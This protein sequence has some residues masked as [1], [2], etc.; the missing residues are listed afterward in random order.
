MSPNISYKQSVMQNAYFFLLIF[1]TEKSLC[2]NQ[3][4]GATC[5]LHL[6]ISSTLIDVTRTKSPSL[7]MGHHEKQTKNQLID[8]KIELYSPFSH[9]NK[10]TFQNINSN[11]K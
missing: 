3:C 1:I 10:Y 7:S 8:R 6:L 5:D 2:T 11:I 4:T 9:S